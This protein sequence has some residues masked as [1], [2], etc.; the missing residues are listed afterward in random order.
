M[1]QGLVASPGFAPKLS[2]AQDGLSTALMAALAA[3]GPEP[4]SL[5]EL[6][7]Q[8][9]ASADE[10]LAVARWNARTGSLV[11]VEPSRYYS[12][13]AVE[14]LTAKMTAAMADGREYVPAELRDMLGLT[15]KFLIPFLE[16]C[17]REGYTFRTGLGRRLMARK[18]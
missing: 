2:A 6:A 16:Y 14:S 12:R 3:T 8:L 18:S 11:A 1:E 7:E 10:I 5:D 9:G 4:P 13:P 15:R 17:D